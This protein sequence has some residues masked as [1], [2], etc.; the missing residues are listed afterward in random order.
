MSCEVIIDDVSKEQWE[1]YAGE[2]ADHSIY[3]TW[4]YQQVRAENDRQELCRVIIRDGDTTPVIMCHVRIKAI[5]PFGPRIGYIQWGPLLRTKDGSI[6]CTL[7]ALAEL[8]RAFVGQRVKVL[9]MVPNVCDD[10]AGRQIADMFQSAGFGFVKSAQSYHTLMLPLD[11][12]EDI[13]RS[14]LH[15]RWRRMLKKVES[16]GIEIQETTDGRWFGTLET[17]CRE[18]AKRKNFKG[19]EV[20]EF[21]RSQEL[22]SPAEK[23]CVI[24]AFYRGE[25]V[26]VLAA[27]AIGDTA[28]V[29]FVASSGKGLELGS[30]YLV[31]WRAIAAFRSKGMKRCDLGGVDFEKNPTVS[32]FKAGMGGVDCRYIGAFEACDSSST[33][34][35][36]RIAE[37]AYGYIRGK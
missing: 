34:I 8:K 28:V 13:L 23:M 24:A 4:G 30:S 31:W 27:S 19:L 26:T 15:K 35:M 11:G 7:D 18:T 12:S 20:Q 9:R 29:L 36:W 1:Q 32:Q 22:L 25:P 10:E 16:A 2:F 17:Y 14:R 3:Q 5:K 21:A 37:K 6:S 33:K